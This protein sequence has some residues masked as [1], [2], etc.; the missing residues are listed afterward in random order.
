[1]RNSSTWKR[2]CIIGYF[3]FLS[4]FFFFFFFFNHGNIEVLRAYCLLSLVSIAIIVCHFSGWRNFFPR[5]G[6][7]MSPLSIECQLAT[8]TYIHMLWILERMPQ[9]TIFFLVGLDNADNNGMYRDII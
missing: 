6:L 4:F 8:Y 3:F 7:W 5:V 1:M 9:V 2:T